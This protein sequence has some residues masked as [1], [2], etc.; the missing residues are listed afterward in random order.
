MASGLDASAL[1][2]RDVDGGC[3]LR[4]KATPRASR[5]EV[6]GVVQ[7]ALRLRLQAPPAEGAA[8][9]R[10]RLFLAE[11]LGCARSAVSLIKGAASREKTF[12]LEGF[13]ASRLREVLSR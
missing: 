6:M 13:T 5:D 11:T 10:A 1:D 12:R 3:L 9:E 2:L 8:N 4:V 7:G